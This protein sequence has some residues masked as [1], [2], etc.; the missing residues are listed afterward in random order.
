MISTTSKS[1]AITSDEGFVRQRR[2]QISWRLWLPLLV[3]AFWVV[4]AIGARWIAPY[5]ANAIN[6]NTALHPPSW[7]HWC[8]TDQLGRDILSRILYGARDALVIAIGSVGLGA[9]MGTILGLWAGYGGP[10]AEWIIMR[11][12]DIFLAIP[13]IVI[14]MVVI[15]ILGAGVSDLI[16]AIAVSEMPIFI[17][18]SRGSTL[19]I[20]SMPYVEA[21]LAAGAS[22]GRIVL[23]HLLRNL[24]G[25]LV[26]LATIDMGAS[27]LAVAGLTFI[28]L[29]P[30][31]PKPEW[32]AMI[33]QA[34][35]Y[36]PQ[37][38]WMAVFPGLAI[39]SAVLSLNIAA[40]E[41]QK[42]IDPGRPNN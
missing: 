6:P 7:A 1:I 9:S 33:T 35:Q 41:W 16:L 31:P 40:D 18:L 17:R 21:A 38:W 29:G 37:D 24:V 3:L 36:I 34:Q 23:S 10:S 26:V 15:T 39:I 2:H 19:T 20:K 4:A 27:I 5:P 32:G 30:P 13:S 28:G 42:F 22:S 8:G 12:T 14:A 11:I 25:T